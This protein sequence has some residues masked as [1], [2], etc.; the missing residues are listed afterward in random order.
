[1][2]EKSLV[3]QGTIYGDTSD[4]VMYNINCFLILEIRELKS[5]IITIK[6]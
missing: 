6:E 3:Y 2:T 1:M 4:V 5:P